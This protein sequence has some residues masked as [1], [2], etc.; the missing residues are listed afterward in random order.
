MIFTVFASVI[1][2]LLWIL[3]LSLI[4]P[5]YRNAKINSVQ[6]IADN[7]ETMIMNDQSLY[8]INQLARD[9]ALCLTVIDVY[10]QSTDFNG[11]GSSCYITY[12]HKFNLE[13]FYVK[14]LESPE[15]E[16]NYFIDNN[17]EM[18]VFGRIIS[19]HLGSYILLINAR[20][21]PEPAGLALIQNQFVFLTIIVLLFATV[22]SLL[23][24]RTFSEPF[25]TLT[26]SAKRLAEGDLD[27]SFDYDQNIYNEV[28]DLADSLNYATD[29]LKKMEQLR[30]DLMAN[31]SHDIKTPLTMIMAYSEMISDFSKNDEEL[32]LEHLDVIRS[33]AKYLD[34]LVEDILELSILQSGN[35]SLNLT[36][37]KIK[38]FIFKAVKHFDFKIDVKLDFDCLVVADE[39]KITQVLYNFINNAHKHANA[40]NISIT[41]MDEGD[42]LRIMVVDDGIGISKEDLDNIWERYYKIDKNF[43]RDYRSS[44]LGLSIAKGIMDSHKQEIGAIS[45]LT[46][47]STFYFTIKKQTLDML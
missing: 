26:K 28:N 46:K 11:I 7:I 40:N 4:T 14:M 44:G 5:Y 31:V 32:L 35:L 6:T 34:T 36:E 17:E 9:N 24:A 33:E 8:P 39:V 47:G 38:D 29:Q 27:V 42:V 20:I 15:H 43:S 25:I 30:L 1:L 18:I 12:N 10:G 16:A 41:V 19:P 37:F 2:L 45:T 13:D 23:I 3:Q 21:T 22:A